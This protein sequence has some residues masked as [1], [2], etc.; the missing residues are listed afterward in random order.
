MNPTNKPTAKALDAKVNAAIDKNLA[1]G[2]RHPGRAVVHAPDLKAV[3][4]AD[5]DAIDA[6]DSAHA[7]WQQ[8]VADE[9]ATHARTAR[10]TRILRNFLL[11]Y[12]GEQA[13]AILSD[14]SLTRPEVDRDGQ[15]R[16]Q[17]PRRAKA[18][19]T[20]PARGTTGSVKKKATVGS[21]TR[22]VLNATPVGATME[23]STPAGT[24]PTASVPAATP[25]TTAP[26]AAPQS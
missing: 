10:F 26:K 11:G 2:H 4:Q 5:S 3:Y 1:T 14:F 21:L 17:G 6:T 13:V 9:R 23:P 16:D 25:A 19:A 20:R 15:R 22:V 7:T 18:K 24:S 8:K 12:F